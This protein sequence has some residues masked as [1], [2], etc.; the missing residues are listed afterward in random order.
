[1]VIK[2]YYHSQTGEISG[3]IKWKNIANEEFIN[4]VLKFKTIQILINL[5]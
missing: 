4:N 1:M 3:L 2:K 5:I